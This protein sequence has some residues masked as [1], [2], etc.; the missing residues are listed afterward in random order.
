ME[1]VQVLIFTKPFW[2]NADAGHALIE[3]TAKKGL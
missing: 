3:E 1:W 2:D